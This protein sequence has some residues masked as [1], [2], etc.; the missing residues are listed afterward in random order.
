MSEQNKTLK[1]GFSFIEVMIV[2]A[3]IALFATLVGP[4]LMGL[5][6]KGRK[7]ATQSTLNVVSGG[8]MQFKADTGQYPAQLE[9]LVRRPE[10]STGW[11]GPYVGSEKDANPQVPK[12]GWGQDLRYELLQRGN[13]PPYKLWS[14]GD[15]DKEEDPIFA[16]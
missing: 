4:R 10:N 3:I 8:I 11:D 15:P 5:L 14:M 7:T 16:K 9:D 13:I 12:D 1:P 2:I 6:G